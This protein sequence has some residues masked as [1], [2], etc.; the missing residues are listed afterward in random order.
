MNNVTQF[1][2]VVDYP[3]LDAKALHDASRG[4]GTAGIEVKRL[5]SQTE[6]LPTLHSRVT[7]VDNAIRATS[8]KLREV[9][10]SIGIKLAINTKTLRAYQA[11]LS[12]APDS[13]RQ[14][15]LE[16]IAAQILKVSNVVNKEH[17]TLKKLHA[18]MTAAVDRIATSQY[19]NQLAADK[20]RLPTEMLEIDSR[21]DDLAEKRK[22]LTQ[23]MALIEAKGFAEVGK[24]TLLNAQEM[25]KLGM[26]G[27]EVAV[28]ETAIE[29]AQQLM[30]KLEQLVNYFGLMDARNTV[31]KQMDD[32]LAKAH[33]KT[34]EL[35]LVDM[36]SNL[37][38]ASHDFDDHRNLY[39]SEFEKIIE[40]NLS[41]LSV[42]RSVD[43]EDQEA[44]SQFVIDASELA[45]HLKVVG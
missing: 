23:A 6:Y 41:F 32:L 35:R 30:E 34:A 27:P 13:D 26:A 16:D 2:S 4:A 3:E 14:E 37:I 33:D 15:I 24:E 43:A 36:K 10:Q 7:D 45:N 38:T 11:E 29:L 42:H 12:S 25:A 5:F 28:V 39:I 40:T 44:V 1:P 18:P 20:V 21:M 19:L 31:R 22:I 9:V 17:N 8:F